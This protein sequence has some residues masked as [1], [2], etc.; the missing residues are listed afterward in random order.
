[1]GRIHPVHMVRIHQAIQHTWHVWICDCSSVTKHTQAANS[2]V[3]RC[4]LFHLLY[5]GQC[6]LVLVLLASL[7]KAV[8]DDL[9]AQAQ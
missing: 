9:A 2:S 3:F 6:L 8:G 5:F 1:M 7:S 4:P